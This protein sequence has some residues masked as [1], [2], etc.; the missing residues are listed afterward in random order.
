MRA[1]GF[2][3]HGVGKHGCPV[4]S[5]VLAGL[6]EAVVVARRVHVDGLAEGGDN[7]VWRSSHPHE[8]VEHRF[9][10]RRTTSVRK[11]RR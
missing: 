4:A 10:Q 5:V 2:P 1:Q 7:V 9:L 11:K 3:H 6:E 8:L